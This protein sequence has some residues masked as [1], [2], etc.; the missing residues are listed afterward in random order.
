MGPG[1]FERDTEIDDR[2]LRGKTMQRNWLQHRKVSCTCVT[3]SS[4]S[5]RNVLYSMDPALIGQLIDSVAASYQEREELENPYTDPVLHD[6][7]R[8]GRFS[9]YIATTLI[10]FVA[11]GEVFN[12]VESI[13]MPW[14]F[15]SCCLFLHPGFS[16][17]RHRLSIFSDQ[18]IYI[19]IHS[20]TS[21]CSP[22]SNS[23]GCFQ[24]GAG[25]DYR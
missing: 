10:S 16:S 25:H 20:D 14:S 21:T 5:M 11:G 8:T 23:C 15:A 6:K 12:V 24:S 3:R 17:G 9:G 7:F 2:H 13:S 22:P 4:F 1:Q 18:Q 19:S